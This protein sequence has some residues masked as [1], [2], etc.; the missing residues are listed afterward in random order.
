MPRSR[1]VK[2]AMREDSKK[3]VSQAFNPA[4]KGALHSALGVSQDKKIPAKKL[5]KA[6]HSKN[7][8][9]KKMAVLAE[10]AKHFKH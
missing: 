3:W 1:S 5:D 6:A 8:L 7:P 2:N 4:R 9:L 10:N